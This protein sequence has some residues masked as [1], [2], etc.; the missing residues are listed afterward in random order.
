MKFLVKSATKETRGLCQFWPTF[1][2][3]TSEYIDSV[4]DMV[5]FMKHKGNWNFFEIY[6]LPIKLRNWFFNRLI[7]YFEDTNEA[8]KK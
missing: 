7:K 3:L 6:A 8:M 4:Y 2:G 1:F 5:F